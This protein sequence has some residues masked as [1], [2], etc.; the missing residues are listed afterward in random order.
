MIGDRL[1]NIKEFKDELRG[2]ISFN[3]KVYSMSD[4]LKVVYDEKYCF[5]LLCSYI[6]IVH[7]TLELGQFVPCVDGVPISKPKKY[8][9]YL[10]YGSSSLVSEADLVKC[11]QYQEAERLVLFKGGFH[12]V[13]EED[14][15]WK[16]NT[17]MYN[18]FSGASKIKDL[19][20]HFTD[21]EITKNFKEL[22][23]K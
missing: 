3:L 19:L 16:D 4:E 13:M 11:K 1:L 18:S 20:T 12:L 10:Q 23:S 14:Y 9:H 6:D 2:Y 21:I 5:N 22:I 15:L 17:K 7:K 8:S